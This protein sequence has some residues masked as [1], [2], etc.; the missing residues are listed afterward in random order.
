MSAWIIVIVGAII[1][2]IG[3]RIFPRSPDS[4]KTGRVF[5]T[6]GLLIFGLGV[7]TGMLGPV[8]IGT[9]SI[10]PFS[11][12]HFMA[13]DDAEALAYA[14]RYLQVSSQPGA[15]WHGASKS[16]LQCTVVN[17][18]D[19]TVSTLTFRFATDRMSSVDV[20]V[21][22]PYHPGQKKMVIIE[23]PAGVP[24]SYFQAPGMNVNQICAAHF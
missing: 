14:K 24:K 4:F 18:G 15:T 3:Q 11:F 20:R 17:R 8:V 21:R 23:V 2:L 16:D 9:T 7:Y 6:I 12:A 10:N 22:G 19:K 13:K 5:S 1:W